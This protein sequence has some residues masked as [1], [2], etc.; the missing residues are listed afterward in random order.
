ML[1]L[2]L[3]QARSPEDPLVKHEQHCIQRRIQGADAQLVARNAIHDTAEIGWLSGVDAV[4]I[5]GSGDF[6]VNHPLSQRWVNPLR[7]LLDAIIEREMPTFGICFGHQLL[8]LHLGSK[9]ETHAAL[10]E[11]GTVEL[12]R[13]SAAAACDVFSALPARFSAHTGHSDHVVSLPPGVELLAR[14]D[15]VEMQAFQLRGLP[16]ITTQFHPDLTGAEARERYLAV[17]RG[18]DAVANRALEAKAEAFHAAGHDHAAGLLRRFVDVVC[19]AEGEDLVA[20][21]GD[22]A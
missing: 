21:E 3:V 13:T 7:H 17:K 15:Q 20:A 10:E 14:G 12:A 18:D 5:G 6:S 8:G 22:V 4:V 16:I 1:S 9:V 19:R 11:V 2:L